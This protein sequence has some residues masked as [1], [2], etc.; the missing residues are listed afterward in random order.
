MAPKLLARSTECFDC[1]KDHPPRAP[2]IPSP[3][4]SI[5]T[6]KSMPTSSETASI[7]DFTAAI[8]A[9]I[10]R[11][12]QAIDRLRCEVAVL[13]RLSD[14]HKSIIAPIRRV[15]SELMAEIFLHLTTIEAS[16]AND[17]SSSSLAN[18]FEKN[19]EV[20]PVLH[21]APLIF[22]EVSRQWR[23]I[24]LSTPTLWNSI[25]ITCT[26]EKL[27]NYISL[28]DTWLKRSGSLPLSIRIHLAP[29]EAVP[30]HVTKDCQD[31]LRTILPYAQRWRL[32][33]FVNV[34]DYSY[35]ILHGCLPKSLPV[36]QALSVGHTLPADASCMFW[37]EL[38]NAPKLRFLHHHNVG[39]EWLT[40]PWSQLTH[41]D[42]GNCS[43]YDCLRILSAAS[44]AVDCTF[45]VERPSS[46]QHP[47]ITHYS[48]KT[49]RISQ[50]HAD[51]HL[52]LT[53]PR[54]ST[55]AV[56][57][58]CSR[59]SFHDLPSFIARSGP[60][61]EN[62]T[63][64][65]STLT[66]TQF[67]TC[68]AYMPKIRHL[69]ISELGAAQ[70]TD[71][72]WKSLTC[73]PSFTPLV[74]DL[75]SLQFLGGRD[76]HHEAVIRMLESRVQMPHGPA[77]FVPKLKTVHLSFWPKIKKSVCRRLTA[78]RF[79]GLDIDVQT[80]VG[81]DDEGDSD[82]EEIDSEDEES[83][84]DDEESDWDDSE[85]SD[86]GDDWDHEESDWEDES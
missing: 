64:E 28:C 86:C 21:R 71:E 31:L 55:L 54:L 38:R 3:F 59:F 85:V 8:D 37:A 30:Q 58:A 48:L 23:T 10:L 5:I 81:S 46:F 66:A 16:S 35:H 53:C 74:P 34:P 47:P 44:A 29:S 83:N 65:G 82:D 24:A 7:H 27:R 14:Q 68:L 15:P 62:F 73:R 18:F 69:T 26:N 36:L 9:E 51:L 20:R 17:T 40:F 4:K 63:L 39:E 45:S 13:H 79:F 12:E 1:G 57:S 60:N 43:E 49:L 75:E 56:S 76:F 67:M 77:S 11:R 42:L 2:L 50:S 6:Q 72:V 33:D 52:R 22:G 32:V 19:D 80:N 84:W 70:F 78:F 25:F 41:I 61:I